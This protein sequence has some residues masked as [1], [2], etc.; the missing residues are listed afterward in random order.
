MI[1]LIL[2]FVHGPGL[3]KFSFV[4]GNSNNN[5]FTKI[6]NLNEQVAGNSCI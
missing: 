1:C 6:F 4:G 5:I 3:I 2:V